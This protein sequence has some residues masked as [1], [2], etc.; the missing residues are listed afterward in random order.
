MSE[1]VYTAEDRITNPHRYRMSPADETMVAAWREDR[2]RRMD[3]VRGESMQIDDA[4]DRLAARCPSASFLAEYLVRPLRRGPDS[5]ALA[6]LPRWVHKW[7][8]AKRL[9]SAYDGNLWRA[10]DWDREP[11]PYLLLHMACVQ[12]YVHGA[13]LPALNAALKLGDTIGSV[14]GWLGLAE[15]RVAYVY[16]T[17]MEVRLAE[18][19]LEGAP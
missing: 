5:S 19:L 16:T 15:E 2:R 4:V 9:V 3:A 7:E 8:V 13:G 10:T 11:A 6:M 18:S 1:Y 12:G 14:H 17:S